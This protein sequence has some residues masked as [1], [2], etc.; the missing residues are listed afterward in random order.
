MSVSAQEG[1]PF[2]L[3]CQPPDG[4]PKPIV[5]WLIQVSIFFKT[6]IY[7]YNTFKIDIILLM[8]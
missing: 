5:N 2:K 8:I 1:E 7:S 3:T 6:Y 4:W